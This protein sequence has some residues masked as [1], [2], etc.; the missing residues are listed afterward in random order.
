M[1]PRRAPA[2]REVHANERQAPQ[3]PNDPLAEQVTN[4]EF[5]A[6]IQMLPQAMTAQVNQGV[7]AFPNPRTMA[8]RFQD[9]TRMNPQEF[10]GSRVDEDP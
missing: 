7:V 6:D 10:Y 3:V 4:A 9:F 8:T 5:Q 2:Q 1:P